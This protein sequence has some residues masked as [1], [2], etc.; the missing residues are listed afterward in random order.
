VARRVVATIITWMAA[1]AIVTLV[2][3]VGGEALAGAPAPV[4]AL[5]V[6]GVLVIVMVNVLMPALTRLI[7]RLFAPRPPTHD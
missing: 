4:R 6:S 1:Y 5:V 7:A 3:L 2:F